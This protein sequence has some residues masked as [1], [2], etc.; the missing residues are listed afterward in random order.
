MNEN[1]TATITLF[2]KRYY[3]EFNNFGII[4][5]NVLTSENELITDKYGRI[6]LKGLMPEPKPGIKYTVHAKLVEDEKW[7][8][9]YE[10]ISMYTDLNI[11]LDDKE[12]Q[13]EFLLVLFTEKQV[14]AMY[15]A[16]DNPYIAFYDKDVESLVKVKGIGF[17]TANKLLNKFH[18]SIDKSRVFVELKEYGLTANMVEKL[19]DHYKSADVIIETVKK[20]PYLLIDLPGIGWKTCDDMALKGGMNPHGKERVCAFIKRYLHEMTEKGCTYVYSNEQLMEAILSMLGE[21]LPDEPIMEA[22]KELKDKLWWSEDRQKVAFKSSIELEEKIAKKM[23]RLADA[24]NRFDFSGWEKK[25][26]EL[27]KKQGWQFT[28]QQY[29]GIK[30]ALE[31]NVV[32]ITGGGGTGKTS[33]VN[34]VLEVLKDPNFAQCALAGRAAARLAEVTGEEGH[35]IHRLLGFPMGEEEDGKF[36]YYEGNYLSY[37]IVIVDEISMVD[38]KLF[39]RLID[40]LKP[41]TKLILLGDTGQLECIGSGNIAH[42][43]I[44]SPYIP[45]IKLTKIHRQAEASAIITDS[46]KIRKN[47]QVIDKNFVGN[48]VKGDLQDLEYNCY[49]DLNNT[50]FNICKDFAEWIEKIDNILDLQIIVPIKDRQSGVWKLNNALQELYNPLLD[51]MDEIEVRYTANHISAIRP[52]DKVM[53]TANNYKALIY[54]NQWKYYETKEYED[55]SD[56]TEVFNGS[57]GIVEAVNSE[58]QEIVVNFQYIGKVLITRNILSQL[59][60]SYAITVHKSQGSQFKYVIV[61]I[62][63]ASYS[64]L[65]K[66]LVYTAITRAVQY[67]KVEAQTNA[68][69]YAISQNAISN[70]QTYLVEAI[71]KLREPVF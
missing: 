70:K 12:S 6:I 62:D 56:K 59:E 36:V 45:S 53:Y 47:I 64:L 61:G 40:A 25:I 15:D 60:L 58:R 48:T 43:L 8:D 52:G 44:E 24:E 55:V 49:S 29:A 42:D 68:L 37:D 28:D 16:L 21:D 26:K 71:R 38:S 41:G 35:T 32:I 51:D 69:R 31:E 2:R 20:N 66:E 14:D 46:L 67:C 11:S 54:E 22:L 57:I 9:Q 23:I 7:G 3:N 10:I 1:I 63:F 34:G 27:E 33:L 4:S 19:Y 17:K 65:T 50:Y 18:N 5:A 39:F 30:A 13:R